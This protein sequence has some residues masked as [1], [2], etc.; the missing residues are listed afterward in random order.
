MYNFLGFARSWGREKGGLNLC[1]QIAPKVIQ[2][3]LRA[4]SL[5][6]V[7]P[8]SKIAGKQTQKA[9]EASTVEQ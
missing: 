2:K 8:A 4:G 5:T 9:L 3:L 6:S 1:N 7:V